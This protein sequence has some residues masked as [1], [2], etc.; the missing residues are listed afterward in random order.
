MSEQI[1]KALMQF[2]A[3]LAKQD[4]ESEDELIDKRIYVVDF[5]KAQL[6]EDMIGQYIDFYDL[7]AKRKKKK[8]LAHESKMTSVGDSVKILGICKKINKTLSQKQKIIVLVRLFEFLKVTES[9]VGTRIEI[10]KTASLVFNISKEEY[11]SI[12]HFSTINKANINKNKNSSFLYIK[13]ESEEK[14]EYSNIIYRNNLEGELVVLKIERENIYFVQYLGEQV[15]SLNNKNILKNRFYLLV[16]GSILTFTNSLAVYYTDIVSVFLS[17]EHNL[18]LSFVAEGITF[19]FKNGT[20]GIQNLNIAEGPGNLV[21]LMGASGAGKSTLMNVLSGNEKPTTGSIRIN[22]IDINE[23][24]NNDLEGVIGFVPQ[25]DLLIEELTVFDNLYYNAKLCFSKLSEVQINKKVIYILDSLGL[26]GAKNLKVGNP[27]DKTISGGQRKRLNIG[28]ELIREPSVLFLDEPT[29]G[30]S[31]KDS[32][33]VIELLREL[34]LKGKLIFVVIHQPSSDIYKMFDKMIF[35]DKGGYLAYYGNPIEAVHYFKEKNKQVEGQSGS[36]KVC[37]TLNSEI[38][39]D[40]LESKIVNE[41]GEFTENRKIAP[42]EWNNFYKKEFLKPTIEETNTPPQKGL[43]IPNKIKQWWLFVQR[44]IFTKLANKQYILITFLEAPI[45]AFILAFIIKKASGQEEYVFA[46]NNNIPS[47]I[48]MSIVVCLF[49][50]LTVS[51]EEIFRDRKILKRERFLNLSRSSYLLSKIT[52]LFLVSAIQCAS[53]VLIG[54]YILEIHGMFWVY[55]STLFNVM[56]LANLIGLNISSTFNSAVTIYIIIPLIIIPQ[57]ILGGAMFKFDNLNDFFGDG[58]DNS[59]PI[60]AEFIPA[61]WAYEGLIVDQFTN[62]YYGEEFFE[63]D[64][65]ISQIK[66][67]QSYLIPILEEKYEACNLNLFLIHGDYTE[68]RFKDDLALMSNLILSENKI[69]KKIQFKEVSNLNRKEFN[70]KTALELKTYLKELK[71]FY[72]KSYNFLNKKKEKKKTAEIK[73]MKIRAFKNAYQNRN[74]KNIVR[75]K[76]TAD[77]YEIID[78]QLIQ[79]TDPIYM[80]NKKGIGAHFY[81]ATK[82]FFGI[83]LKTAQFNRL[84]IFIMIIFAYIVLYFNLLSKL[85]NLTDKLKLKK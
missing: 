52:I 56:I 62:S 61:R 14:E 67:K 3:I 24:I 65:R 53:F 72:A 44:G 23:D 58:V 50:G 37:G 2:F 49:L 64:K 66:F 40:I 33:N 30:L 17:E 10:I 42:K 74:V 57:M 60:I 55:F 27:L 83:E 19:K 29:S 81:A 45:L 35:L 18:N 34:V 79:L 51:A 47:Y 41:Y 80:K 63:L 59:V 71:Q 22:G 26:I 20:T 85:L 6:S 1:L 9:I 69:L 32:L 39:F 36:C 54:N 25:D 78:N 4:I 73:G 7:K 75:N 68:E 16:N 5:L 15:V 70:K 43:F 46:Y 13:D 84:I 21:G 28:L 11:D 12:Y 77:D 31:S 76:F 8:G 38:I 48:F 82:T